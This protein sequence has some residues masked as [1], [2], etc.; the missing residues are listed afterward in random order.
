MSRATAEVNRMV[1]RRWCGSLNEQGR[2]RLETLSQQ[3]QTSLSQ[4]RVSEIVLLIFNQKLRSTSRNRIKVKCK[5]W[6][7]RGDSN[8]HAFRHMILN[9]ARLPIPTL[10]HR[11]SS[12]NYTQTCQ[13]VSNRFPSLKA[14][15]LLRCVGLTGKAAGQHSLGWLPTLPVLPCLYNRG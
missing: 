1:D 14:R 7:G 4:R 6:W 13:Y 9:H 11:K 8:S 12:M 5:H 2:R 15:S 10:P 3:A